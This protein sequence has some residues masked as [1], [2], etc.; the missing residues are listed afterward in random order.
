MDATKNTTPETIT[1]AGDWNAQSKELK[2]RYTQLTDADL[3]FEPGKENDL[4]SR[5]QAR[6]N[7]KRGEVI[8]LLRS[9]QVEKK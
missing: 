9:G 1:L 8:E 5:V 6:L 2:T 3:K 7:K 4:I